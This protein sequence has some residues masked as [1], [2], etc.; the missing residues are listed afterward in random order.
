MTSNSSFVSS[1]YQNPKKNS[2][3]QQY[4]RENLD[5][6]TST[7]PTITTLKQTNSVY[8]PTNYAKFNDPPVSEQQTVTLVSNSKLV[9]DTTATLTTSDIPEITI[10]ENNSN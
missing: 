7:T 2:R 4:F 6:S 5:Q 10:I 9:H 3:K 1:R 8:T